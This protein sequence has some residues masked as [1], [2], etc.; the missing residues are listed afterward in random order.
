MAINP[1]I[2]WFRDDL[3]LQDL[4]GLK[5]AAAQGCPVLA[6]YI[7]DDESPGHWRK[8]RASRWWLHHS[9]AAL[10]GRIEAAGGSLY[11]ASGNPEQVLGRLSQ[12]TGATQIYCS[13]SYE[14]WAQ[15]LERRLHG[16]LS[17]INVEL[18][19]FEGSMLREPDLVKTQAGTPFKVY[20]PFWK[21]CRALGDP[22][23]PTGA[24]ALTC[25]ANMK[26][27]GAKLAD[28]PLTD[29]ADGQV[30]GWQSHWQPG[31]EG[32]AVR[33]DQFLDE[34]LVFYA[35]ERDFPG[36]E[37]TSLLSAHLHFGE[38]SP[39]RVYHAVRQAVLARPELEQAAEKFLSELGWR[40]FSRYLL[41]HF[42]EVPEKAFKPVFEAFPWVGSAE[43]L[44]AWQEGNTGY[45]LVDAGMRELR[46]TGYMHGRVRMVAASFLCKHLL[47]DWRAGERFFWDSLVDAD[48]ANNASGW[49][50]VAGSGADAAPYFRIF[51][52]ITQGKKFDRRGTYVR[53]WIP[54][55]AALPDRYL[56]Q[57]WEAPRSLLQE[58]KVTLGMDYPFPVVEHKPARE[59][60]L[61]AYAQMKAV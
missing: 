23:P 2:Y 42:P 40:E 24:L 34:R 43:N 57:P 14:P 9:L 11:L 31:E 17:A 48:L 36:C 33:L 7:L 15:A 32:A 38:I 12:E 37:A 26:Q 61:A 30:H 27:S 41:Y 21:A 1:V 6:C 4:P 56:F 60:A 25:C 13:R 50:W 49:Q 3:R 51:N 55:L 45:P 18:H 22:E 44:M 39:N 16:T 8:G 35:Q 29:V 46:Q 19:R 58:C 53:R 52:P 59:S 5:A 54:E 10:S 28:L 20:T 47:I